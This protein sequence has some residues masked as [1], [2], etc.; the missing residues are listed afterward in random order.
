M[1]S[2]KRFSEELVLRNLKAL[3]LM[4][5]FLIGRFCRFVI[6]AHAENRFSPKSFVQKG[7]AF[8]V[9]NL[10]RKFYGLKEIVEIT[11]TMECAHDNSTAVHWCNVS[12]RYQYFFLQLKLST[13]SHKLAID[14]KYDAKFIE[15]F[16]IWMIYLQTYD[17]FK[18]NHEMKTSLHTQHV[19][20]LDYVNQV[21]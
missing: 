5:P 15:I 9:W 6:H 7:K 1:F 8:C 13:L 20:N 10:S 12:L 16:I 17:I 2:L 18:V 3:P 4:K 11:K 14:D 19:T 21:L